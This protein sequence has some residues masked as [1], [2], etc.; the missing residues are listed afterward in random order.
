MGHGQL[1]FFKRPTR[2]ITLSGHLC[3]SDHGQAGAHAWNMK[4]ARYQGYT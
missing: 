2:C 1:G 4:N 3:K